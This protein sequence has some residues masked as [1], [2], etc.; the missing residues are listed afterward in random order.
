MMSPQGPD[1]VSFHLEG[2]YAIGALSYFHII[3]AAFE[4]I[5]ERIFAEFFRIFR[6]LSNDAG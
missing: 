2:P 3:D 4:S 6:Q 5:A 1:L